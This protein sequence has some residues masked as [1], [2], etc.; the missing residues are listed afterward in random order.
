[1]NNFF[2]GTDIHSITVT[3][4]IRT[5]PSLIATGTLNAD[6][7]ISLGK[8]DTALAI[9]QLQNTTIT[10]TSPLGQS[11][12][13][14]LFKFYTDI[15]SHVGGDIDNA[16]FQETFYKAQ[17]GFWYAK[18]QSEH[19]VNQDEEL[20]FSMQLQNFYAAGTKVISAAQTMF[21]QLISIV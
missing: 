10:I 7:S 9:S 1:M 2:S 19:G 5:N 15:A 4:A 12:K 6:G 17:A 13:T 21:D 8:N 18:G 11:Q 14:T 16:S 20:T 3:D